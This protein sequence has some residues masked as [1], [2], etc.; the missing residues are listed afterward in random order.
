MTQ[1]I[2]AIYR[3]T[4]TLLAFFAFLVGK[5]QDHDVVKK[6]PYYINVNDTPAD[7]VI[8]IQDKVLSILYTDRY[9]QWKNISL[10]IYDWK[11]VNV[12]TLSL[13]KVY[14]ANYYN[15]K[16]DDLYG[17][18]ENDR[19]YI[20]ELTNE[21][22]NKYKLAIR[23]VPPPEKP[24]PVVS[25]IVNPVQLLCD[26]ISATVV[27]F[28]GDILGGKAPYTIQWAVMNNNRTGL[29]Y[30]PLEEV[31]GTSGIT[32]AITVDKAPDYYVILE[33]KDA[34]GNIVRKE[35]HMMCEAKEKRIST[36]FVEPI[37]T[38]PRQTQ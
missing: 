6:N 5:A 13:A 17:G 32:S 37:T 23:P 2:I 28:V 34:C 9:A 20:C 21:T 30:Q 1:T 11:Q 3:T 26:G 38:V 10:K 29:L 31:I 18:W 22:G 24:D 15:I 16:L 12:A 33:V 35:V 36:I 8:P 14:G 4:F 7:K 25:I 27:E 19:I